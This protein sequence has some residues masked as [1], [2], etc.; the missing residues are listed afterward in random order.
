[1]NSNYRNS[2]D[3]CD[4]NVICGLDP[5]GSATRPRKTTA[6]LRPLAWLSVMSLL[7]MYCPHDAEV[8]IVSGS[9]AKRLEFAINDH[10][11]PLLRGLAVVRCKSGSPPVSTIM[12]SIGD[13][14]QVASPPN[15]I[16]YGTTPVGWREYVAAQPLVPGCYVT[17]ISGLAGT[18]EFTVSAGGQL[19]EVVADSN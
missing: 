10:G 7:A 14:S 9:T 2:P 1:M 5:G 11:R 6:V 17:S 15:R 8:H 4:P 3:P 13:T 18:R 12:W 16:R 19:Q